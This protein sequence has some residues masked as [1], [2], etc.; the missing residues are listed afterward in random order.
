MGW[1]CGVNTKEKVNC[2]PEFIS[3][4]F[5]TVAVMWPAVSQSCCR[6]FPTMM[7][8]LCIL[9]QNKP[10]LLSVAFLLL[11]CYN[12]KIIPRILLPMIVPPFMITPAHLSLYHTTVWQHQTSLWPPAFVWKL[13]WHSE[14]I[15][16]VR[17]GTMLCYTYSE[18]RNRSV[19]YHQKR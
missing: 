4:C 11:F 16:T 5:L 12:K 2:T 14:N 6:A 19:F 7:D 15:S 10:F 18:V 3:L 17:V 13:A 1:G 8:W 9:R